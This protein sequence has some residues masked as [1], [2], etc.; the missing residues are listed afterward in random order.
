[1]DVKEVFANR[2]RELRIAK[3]LSQVELAE[4]L[5]VSRGSISFYENGERTAD[6]DFVY[7]AAQFFNVSADY[8]IGRVDISAQK[9]SSDGITDFLL[10][11][12]RMSQENAECRNCESSPTCFFYNIH[13]KKE[14]DKFIEKVQ[15]WAIS[16]PLKTY[17]QDFFEKFPNAPKNNK[18]LPRACR[19]DI[20]GGLFDKCG[21]CDDC[22]KE[23]LEE[24]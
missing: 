19:V 5:G 4:A 10:E 2:L 16:H 17:A 11:L 13:T 22:W 23:P 18:G 12:Q 15:A 3:K 1:M 6:I 9:S 8:L 7:K 20:Y 14:M 24:V 21:D